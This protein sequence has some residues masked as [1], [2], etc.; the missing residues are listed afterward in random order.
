[1]GKSNAEYAKDEGV[2]VEEGVEET[3]AYDP[4]EHTVEEVKDELDSASE[5]EKMRIAAAEQA[6]KG[7]KSVLAAAGVDESVRLDA[8]GRRLHPWEIL[9]QTQE[10]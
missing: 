7:R 8:S 2:E 3:A 5:S 6:G 9:P 10:A 1:M 4:S